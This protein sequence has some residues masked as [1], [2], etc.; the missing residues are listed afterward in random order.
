[1]S[2]SKYFEMCRSFIVFVKNHRQ[3]MIDKGSFFMTHSK[4][5]RFT[6]VTSYLLRN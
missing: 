3:K 2:F 5:N 1:M 4:N 6:V